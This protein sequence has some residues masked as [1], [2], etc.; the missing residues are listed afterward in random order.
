MIQPV[1]VMIRDMFGDQVFG[2]DGQTL[3]SVVVQ[4]LQ[5]K[6][7]RVA[8]AESCSADGPAGRLST[9]PGRHRFWKGAS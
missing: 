2:Q 3:E 7:W 4:L 9:A 1:E 6:G 8:T 5:E